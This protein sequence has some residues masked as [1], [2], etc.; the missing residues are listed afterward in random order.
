VANWVR[1]PNNGRKGEPVAAI[2]RR[3]LVVDDSDTDL[4]FAR[5]MLER[6]HCGFEVITHECAR[7]AL[8]MLSEAGHDVQLIL[9]DINMPGMNG[10]EFLD[11]YDRLARTAPAEPVV[12]MLSS[13]PLDTDRE[14]ALAHP[15][16]RGYLVKPLDVSAAAGLLRY[17]PA[18]G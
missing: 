5:L 10:F 1:A 13:S 6:A 11:A 15:R 16:V 12:V 2:A 18:E 17:L 7:D 9:L 3:V 8:Q 4:L 14:R